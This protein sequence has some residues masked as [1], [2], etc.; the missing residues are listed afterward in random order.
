MRLHNVVCPYCGATLTPDNSTKEHVVGRRFV[1]KGTLENEW[2]LILNACRSCNNRKADLEDDISAITMQPD[3][4][5]RHFGA[6]QQLAV[7]A[8]RKREKTFSRH[9]GKIVGESRSTLQVKYNL[10]PGATLT[11]NMIGQEQIAEDRIFELARRHFQAFFHFITYDQTTARGWWWKGMFAQILAVSQ[12]LEQIRIVNAGNGLIL[13][14]R[15]GEREG[16]TRVT[17]REL[18]DG[19]GVDLR[20]LRVAACHQCLNE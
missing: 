9:T 20:D 2:N 19:A 15:R 14:N 7:D 18:R 11:F 17:A 10:G 16:D 3:A 6:H 12:P 4:S 1:P 8:A 5:G 13:T